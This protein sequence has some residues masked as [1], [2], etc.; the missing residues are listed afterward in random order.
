MKRILSVLLIAALALMGA[1][2]AEAVAPEVIDR[3]SDTWVADG[4]SAEIWF[5]DETSAFKCELALKDETFCDFET[6]VYDADNDALVCSE[7]SRYTAD[8]NEQTADYDKDIRDTG[9]TATFTLKDEQ[10]TCVDSL[11][12]LK[13]VTF[14]RLD[15]S[16]AA[17]AAVQT[18]KAFTQADMDA[19]I[20]LID[21]EFNTWKGCVMN[22]LR[23]AGDIENNAENLKW[24]SDLKGK[25]YTACMAFLSDFHSPVEGGG[26]WEPDQDYNDYQWWLAREDGGSWELVTWG[27]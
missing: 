2:L 12:L 6:C 11:D 13:G 14:I 15:A 24:L 7:G 27:Y 16:E 20:A 25:K 3:F 10:L 21:A 8:Y 19:A 26:A 22:S 1:A 17:D 4:Y 23:Y 18:T 5:D 9:I